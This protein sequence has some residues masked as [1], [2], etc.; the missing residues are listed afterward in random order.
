MA[1]THRPRAHL[2]IA[3]P[4]VQGSMAWQTETC[5]PGES[6]MALSDSCYCSCCCVPD[7][8]T[9]AFRIASIAV[10]HQ[11]HDGMAINYNAGGYAVW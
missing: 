5:A 4:V 7:I 8:G 10:Q 11:M 2:P 3:P 1:T 9:I 6:H